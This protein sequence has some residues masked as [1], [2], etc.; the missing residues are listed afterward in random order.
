MVVEVKKLEEAIELARKLA[1]EHARK[2]GYRLNPDP[3][4]L[5]R[6]LRGLAARFI[7]TG[8]FY[9]P[10]RIVKGVPEEDKN[11]ECP[12]V[13]H[14]EEICTIGHCK[15]ELFFAEEKK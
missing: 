7:K 6:V 8:K 12:C 14:E 4:R 2:M 15:C 3:I 5:E 13:Y 10:C 1:R 9:C 11:I